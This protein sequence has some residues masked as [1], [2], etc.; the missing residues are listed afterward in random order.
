MTASLTYQHA[1]TSDTPL[2]FSTKTFL[3]GELKYKVQEH[4]AKLTFWREKNDHSFSHFVTSWIQNMQTHP[5]SHLKVFF[6][7]FKI[8]N[9]S[10]PYLILYLKVSKCNCYPGVRP[11]IHV[12]LLQEA[13]K[14]LSYNALK[15]YQRFF[16]AFWG[17]FY[18]DKALLLAVCLKQMTSM[19]QT[20]KINFAHCPTR[21]SGSQYP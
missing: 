17:D 21:E 1:R 19:R 13:S 7:V 18:V 12:W 9:A 3:V 15:W 16:F 20:W 11:Q 2:G 8:D 4:R 14:F 5:K 6:K 10:Y